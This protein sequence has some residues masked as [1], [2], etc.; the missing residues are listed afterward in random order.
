VAD[1]DLV[2]MTGDS[3]LAAAATAIGIAVAITNA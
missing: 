3:D 1:G 2:V